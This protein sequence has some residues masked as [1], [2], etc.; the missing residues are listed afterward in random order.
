[1]DKPNPLDGAQEIQQL[2]I[3]Y[4]RQ[5]TVDPL[6]TLGRYLGLGLAGSLLVFTGVFF[7]G[8][9]AL[10]F[11][12]SISTFEGAGWPSTVPYLTSIAVLAL[13]LALIA[14][15]LNRAKKKVR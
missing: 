7:V 8:L 13:F 2:L 12:Q 1:M 6:K 3:A 4:A 15:T 10:R 11:M 14:L 5:E 9:G